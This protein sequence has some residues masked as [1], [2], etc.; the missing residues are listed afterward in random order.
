MTSS[1][2]T[3][4]AL[5]FNEQLLIKPVPTDVKVGTVRRW[6]ML[7]VKR[8]KVNY[9]VIKKNSGCLVCVC[10]RTWGQNVFYYQVVL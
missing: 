9:M 6:E 8:D 7:E 4:R 3:R 2:T 5:Q 10:V 1:P